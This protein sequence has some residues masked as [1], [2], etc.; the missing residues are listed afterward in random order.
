MVDPAALLAVAA[1]GCYIA[2]SVPAGRL[3]L[4]VASGTAE[5]CAPPGGLVVVALTVRLQDWLD[6]A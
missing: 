5:S 2:F 4:I 3:L 6:G 1:G